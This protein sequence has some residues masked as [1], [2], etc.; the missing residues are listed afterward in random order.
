M[1]LTL[2]TFS[3]MVTIFGL[4]GA[5]V[6]I[7]ISSDKDVRIA[8][9]FAIAYGFSA[10]LVTSPLIEMRRECIGEEPKSDICAKVLESTGL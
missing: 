3:M 4:L 5:M 6:Y 10:I 8:C 9:L 7:I 2:M 1:Y